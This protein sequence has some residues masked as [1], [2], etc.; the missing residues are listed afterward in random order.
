MTARIYPPSI[1][2]TQLTIGKEKIIYNI[3]SLV[4]VIFNLNKGIAYSGFARLYR[5]EITMQR[6]N[7]ICI[8]TS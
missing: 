6:L 3:L 1:F 5:V 2:V 7:N 4:G 8:I